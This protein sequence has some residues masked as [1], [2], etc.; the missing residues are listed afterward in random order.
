M[1]SCMSYTDFSSEVVTQTSAFIRECCV[2]G[3][4]MYVEYNVLMCSLANY[5]LSMNA[6]SSDVHAGGGGVFATA[7]ELRSLIQTCARPNVVRFHNRF[8]PFAQPWPPR[9]GVFMVVNDEDYA[10]VTGIALKDGHVLVSS[11]PHAN[12]V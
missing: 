3:P 4:G 2:L 12:E 10:F 8:Y 7:A 1:G 6:A 5:T 11:A 9:H